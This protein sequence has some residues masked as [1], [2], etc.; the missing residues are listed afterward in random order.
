M[1]FNWCY[2]YFQISRFIIFPI[3]VYSIFI[4][5]ADFSCC[6]VVA[7]A[8]ENLPKIPN[9]VSLT[10]FQCIQTLQHP[11]FAF[12][13][14]SV[15]FFNYWL[16]R[17][18]TILERKTNDNRVG[19]NVALFFKLYYNFDQNGPGQGWFDPALLFFSFPFFS[20][21]TVKLYRTVLFKPNVHG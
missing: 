2:G 14:L 1:S 12:D 3:F 7:V 11:R 5:R 19:S 18:L 4:V 21:L 15:S 9:I 8:E 10:N 13:W 6:I 16:L 20:H 17:L